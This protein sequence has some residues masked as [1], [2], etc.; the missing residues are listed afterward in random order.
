MR[1][2]GAEE[3]TEMVLQAQVRN[4]EEHVF[5]ICFSHIVQYDAEVRKS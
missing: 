1:T 5:L 2:T 4:C 3:K